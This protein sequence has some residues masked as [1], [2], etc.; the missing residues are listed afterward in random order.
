MTFHSIKSL[1]IAA[2]FILIGGISLGSLLPIET[3]SGPASLIGDK[4]QHFGAYCLL[5]ILSILSGR[6]LRERKLLLLVSFIWSIAIEVI[7]P[8]TGRY[9]EWADILANGIGLM[10]SIPMMLF[11]EAGRRK[12]MAQKI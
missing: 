4:A 12:L 3:I 8:V 11:F 1:W 5:G 9:F 6:N 2:W 7:Q 10:A